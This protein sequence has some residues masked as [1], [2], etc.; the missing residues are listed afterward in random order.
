LKLAQFS[1]EKNM[2]DT[3][4]EAQPEKKKPTEQAKPGDNA[5]TVDHGDKMS[6]VGGTLLS[7]PD[8]RAGGAATQTNKSWTAKA[9]LLQLPTSQI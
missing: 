2:A 7:T 6:S 5:T 8:S 1:R 4:I 9:D 3:V